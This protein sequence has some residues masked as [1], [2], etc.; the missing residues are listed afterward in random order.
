MPF[1]DPNRL[2]VL[3]RPCFEDGVGGSVEG[4]DSATVAACE[5]YAAVAPD[6]GPV[7]GGGCAGDGADGFERRGAEEL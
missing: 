5:N 6:R 2:F 7:E 1:G 4:L 3:A